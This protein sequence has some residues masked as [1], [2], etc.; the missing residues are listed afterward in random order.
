MISTPDACLRIMHHN[1]VTTQ[2]K[3]LQIANYAIDECKADVISLN[4]TRLA[5][6]IKL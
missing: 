5:P 2:N 6:S 3:S 1:I 4:E